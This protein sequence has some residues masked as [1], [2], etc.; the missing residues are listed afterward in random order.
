V[1][2]TRR[3]F[4]DTVVVGAAG[5][6]VLVA[7]G[8]DDGSGSDGG[9]SSCTPDPTIASNHGHDVSVPA[10]HVTAG[11]ERTYSIQGTS[12]HDHMITVTASMFA[13]LQNG[14]NVTVGS[15]TG[16]AD[17]HNHQVTLRC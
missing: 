9:S 10:A 15:T 11:T 5:V 17:G 8:D 13:D 3:K 1:Q 14:M 6:T 4:L 12:S 7:C 2:T 16:G